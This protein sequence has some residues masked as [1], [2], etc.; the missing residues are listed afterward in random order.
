MLVPIELHNLTREKGYLSPE[1]AIG[2]KVG[3]Y[4]A[5]FFDGLENITVTV[6]NNNDALIALHHQMGCQG[7]TQ[8][9][10]TISDKNPP[11]DFLFNHGVTGTLLAISLIHLHTQLP[12]DICKLEPDLKEENY[13]VTGVYQAGVDRLISTLLSEPVATFARIRQIRYRR[14]PILPH[15]EH[16]LQCEDCNKPCQPGHAWEIEGIYLC[17]DCIGF[18]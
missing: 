13:A 17:S 16:S 9:S 1:L 6:A 4:A 15:G 18:G 12:L 7:Q 2:W 14:L 5:E 8:Q 10:V 3:Q 11:W